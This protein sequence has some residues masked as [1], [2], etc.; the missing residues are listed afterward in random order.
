MKKFLDWLIDFY[1]A[2][3][4]EQTALAIQR[5]ILGASGIVEYFRMRATSG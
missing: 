2:R 5:E 3:N 4:D 1:L